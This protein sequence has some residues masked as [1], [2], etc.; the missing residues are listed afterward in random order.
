M[1]LVHNGK[2]WIDERRLGDWQDAK[3]EYRRLCDGQCVR[4]IFPASDPKIIIESRSEFAASEHA[5]GN[6]PDLPIGFPP[7]LLIRHEGYN[8]I[9][10]SLPDVRKFLADPTTKVLPWRTHS[11]WP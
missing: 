1:L 10:E 7:Y 11:R 2:E 3:I 5:T 4:H 9:P 6:F 8:P